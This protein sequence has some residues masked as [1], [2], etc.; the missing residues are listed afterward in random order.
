MNYIFKHI[1]NTYPD[2]EKVEM[3]ISAHGGHMVDSSLM[4]KMAL[5]KVEPSEVQTLQDE[6]QDWDIYPE[7]SYTVPPTFFDL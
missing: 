6:L 4:P 3:A 7:K 2:S 5:V 1:G